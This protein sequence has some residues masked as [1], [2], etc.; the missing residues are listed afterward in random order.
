VSSRRHDLYFNRELSWLEFNW[1]VL[2]EAIDERTPLLERLKF[3]AI[4]STN[5]DEF[6]M[7]RVGG[8]KRQ[9]AAGVRSLSIDGRTPRT[10]LH[11]IREVVL[12]MV[13]AKRRCLLDVLLPRLR[14]EGVYLL[15]YSEIRDEDR[16]HLRALY[17]RSIFPVLTPLGVDPGHPFPF[18]SNLSVSLAVR[19]IV[20]GNGGERFAR[21]KVPSNLSRWVELSKPH[22]FVPVEQVIANN[23]NDLFPGTEVL[24][25]QPFRITRNADLERNEE[26]AEDLLDLIEEELRH[27][28]FAPVVRLEV[29][30]G[31]SPPLC[32]WLQHS[33]EAEDS[34]VYTVSGP[35]RLGDLMQLAK[36]DMP[37]LL[38]PPLVSAPHP[39]LRN[40][41]DPDTDKDVFAVIREGDFLVHH[42]YHSFTTSVL[43]VLER[44]ADDPQVLGI[45]QTLYRTATNSPI[46]RALVR[47]ANNGKQVAVLV[48]IKARFDEA[49]N[50]E[51]VKMLESA[52]VHVS[53]G[54]VGLKTHSKTLLVVREEADGIRCYY[55]IG[56]GNYHT[57]TAKLYTDLGLFSCDEELGAEVIHLFNFLTGHSR[58]RDYRRLLVAPVNMRE[59]LLAMIEREVEQHR[60][61][62]PGHI[63]AK[64]NSLEDRQIIDA[65][66]RAS[67]AGVQLDLI[68]RGFCCLRPGVPGV[69]ENIR[70]TSTIGRLLEHSRIF[71]F[72]NGGKDEYYIGSAD[73]MYRNL[74]WRVEAITPV[75]APELKLQLRDILDALL[76]DRRQTWDL[77]SDGT[78]TQRQ[79]ET[80]EQEAGVQMLLAASPPAP[81]K[82]S[83]SSAART[84]MRPA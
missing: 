61:E 69:S 65:L 64:M 11:E 52:G 17:R 25:V 7:K 72:R 75:T 12:K 62:E 80:P 40:L 24:E 34:D 70:V 50:I 42:P 15:D 73:W 56:T 57:E 5:L 41:E 13:E 53:Y 6:F 84:V 16:E 66:Y 27:R 31:T 55:H 14:K 3:I 77:N 36:I 20:P 8:L 37:S 19:L 58:F 2:H 46:I 26:E 28:R 35:L 45:K 78:Y 39:R 79:P 74:D 82:P 67:Q 49:N 4:V 48:E 76:R 43:Q 18:L 10:Q 63:I 21:V 23:L 71:Y 83:A 51:W 54:L 47:A 60:P 29:A 59:R 81:E 68:V 9:L 33:L 1:R 44:A 22:H 30:E 38:Y 32:Q